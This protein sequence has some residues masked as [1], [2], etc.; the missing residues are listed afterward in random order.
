MRL[1]RY[2]WG[3]LV[4]LDKA[5]DSKGQDSVG[6]FMSCYFEART[7]VNIGYIHFS[8]P[9]NHSKLIGNGKVLNV[10]SPIIFGKP[11]VTCRKIYFVLS[12]GALYFN[13]PA[14]LE[15]WVFLLSLVICKIDDF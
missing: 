12:Y 7:E 10:V 13:I 6:K 14:F 8:K 5:G 2:L 15:L 11:V 1:E 3:E 9:C 4:E